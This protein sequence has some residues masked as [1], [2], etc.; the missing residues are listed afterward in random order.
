MM[1]WRA[2]VVSCEVAGS[3]RGAVKV[4]KAVDLVAR[5][6]ELDSPRGALGD[7]RATCLPSGKGV[8]VGQCEGVAQRVVPIAGPVV[9]AV[10]GGS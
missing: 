1:I 4:Q 7:E 10:S 5:A 8:G 2:M 3:R 6:V 9:F